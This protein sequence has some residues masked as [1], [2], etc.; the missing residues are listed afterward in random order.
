MDLLRCELE[1]AQWR[2]WPLHEWLA[3]RPGGGGGRGRGGG[4]QLAWS[5]GVWGRLEARAYL[6]AAPRLLHAAAAREAKAVAARAAAEWHCGGGAC[7]GGAGAR[8][9]GA[10]GA[11]RRND[12]AD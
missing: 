3:T 1:T 2:H 12:W 10:R 5:S 8:A 11:L 6:T 9:A 7:G 4:G